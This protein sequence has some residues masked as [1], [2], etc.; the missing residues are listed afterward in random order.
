MMIHTFV[1]YI[2]WDEGLALRDA[3]NVSGIVAKDRGSNVMPR[4]ESALHT[5]AA[6][7]RRMNIGRTAKSRER[8]Y[9]STHCPRRMTIMTAVI[10]RYYCCAYVCTRTYVPGIF[11]ANLAH[12]LYAVQLC[13][14]CELPH[15]FDADEQQQQQHCSS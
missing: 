4:V 6:L 11:V 3:E 7:W 1:P 13:L 14:P 2:V 9:P 15:L 12:V 8:W 10:V 5:L